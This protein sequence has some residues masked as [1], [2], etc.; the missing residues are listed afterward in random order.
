MQSEYLHQGIANRRILLGVTG[1]IAAYKA[2]ELVR[3][4]RKAGAEVRVDADVMH[5]P[6]GAAP[7]RAVSVTT[8]A[9]PQDAP[10]GI[11]TRGRS[12]SQRLLAEHSSTGRGAGWM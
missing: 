2:A 10:A 11:S 6:R 7:L 5:V 9:S 12:A 8:A 3:G 1:G 4:L